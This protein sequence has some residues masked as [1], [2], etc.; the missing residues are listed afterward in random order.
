MLN[1]PFLSTLA[2]VAVHFALASSAGTGILNAR[3]EL[4]SKSGAKYERHTTFLPRSVSPASKYGICKLDQLMLW[5][6]G[7]ITVR[8]SGGKPMRVR[9][10]GIDPNR[11][12]NPPPPPL[13]L[14]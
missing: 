7:G 13:S 14:F 11:V 5:R 10:I 3:F 2:G 9:I 8:E 1:F 12:H 4:E 6:D